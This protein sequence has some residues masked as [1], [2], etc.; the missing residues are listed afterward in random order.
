MLPE[1]N[2]SK[3]KA[4]SHKLGPH[5][6]KMDI[7]LHSSIYVC[8]CC[9]KSMTE[10][11]SQVLAKPQLEYYIQSR[12]WRG[13]HLFLFYYYYLGGGEHTGCRILVPQPGIEPMLPVL[14]LQNLNHW[15]TR[16]VPWL[17]VSYTQKKLILGTSL[18]V[19]WLRLCAPSAGGLVRELDPIH[20]D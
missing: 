7:W 4:T 17:E 1:V 2:Q 9:L 13:S 6:Y 10:C 12:T 8:Y 19:Q 3:F 11:W 18:V 16:E 20:F 5:T 15:T 14:G